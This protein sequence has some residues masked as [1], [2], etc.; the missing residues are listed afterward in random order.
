MARET[1]SRIFFGSP[2]GVIAS[3]V[4]GEKEGQVD[5]ELVKHSLLDKKTIVVMDREAQRVRLYAPVAV[6]DTHFCLVVESDASRMY[7]LLAKSR[8]RFILASAAVLLFVTLL[9]AVFAVRI[10]GP[11]WLLRRRAEGVIREYAPDEPAA[12]VRG[13]EVETLVRAFD[14]MVLA[15]R[16]HVTARAKATDE[17]ERNRRDLEMRVRERTAELVKANEELRSAKE[18]A[19]AANRAK[20]Q[21]LAN[22]SH[23]I[24][25]PMNGVLG[26]LELLRIG[27]LDAGP[28]AYVEMALGSGATLLQLIND[29]LDFSK[30][31]AGR[32]EIAVTDLDLPRL[33]E[34]VVD[35][36]GEQARSK[37]IELA[38]QVAPGVPPDLRGDPLRLRQIIVNLLGN[39]VKFTERGGV[40]VRVSSAEG[41]RGAVLLTVEVADTGV[42]ISPEARPRIFHAF[43]QQDGST[44]RRFG[45]TG[46][47]LT[48]ARQLVQ[49]MGGEIDFKS[50]P[51]EGSTF[52]FTV[53]LDRQPAPGAAEPYS[54]S[55]QGLGVLVA[56]GTLTGRT[57]LCRQLEG[58]GIRNGNAE[59]GPRALEMLVAALSGDAYQVAI[60]DA[61]APGMEGKEL[62]RAI[63][64]DERLAGMK[65]IL[66]TSGAETGERGEDPGV[67]AY[68]KKPVRQSHL[69]NVLVS[70]MNRAAPEAP[71]RAQ[72]RDEQAGWGEYSSFRILLVEDN[73][74]NQAVSRAMLDFFGCRTDVVGN[75]REA[76]QAVARVRYDLILMDCQMPEMDGY[77]ATRAIRE[78][79]A[80]GEGHVPIVALT[81]H[82]MEGDREVCLAAG[83]DD[84]LSKP[85]KPDELRA[86]LAKWL[87]SGAA[88]SWV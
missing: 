79:E 48:I 64:A 28:K 8:S 23:E 42:G 15:V 27:R 33:M 54:A 74:V 67:H 49:M 80:A 18:A 12:A 44:T 88:P 31:E 50:A 43:S 3:S 25:T 9:G 38:C 65:L 5:P 10:T 75:G 46:L 24:R 26:F 72:L 13:N 71:L 41:E 39:A 70:L 82:A 32:L 76:L 81:A 86:V 68:L 60:I 55:F 7:L 2:A 14:R 84:Y 78:G 30:I 21:F 34:E 22:M 20:S 63:R 69:Y 61:A 35:L 36:F 29:I 77:E 83:M 47:G 51:G 56:A 17:L 52:W 57:I 40:T 11:L 59:S 87:V 53:R 73:P 16:E 19:E 85:Y 66:L 45:G 1:A 4:D 62:I 58:W 6:V 37:G